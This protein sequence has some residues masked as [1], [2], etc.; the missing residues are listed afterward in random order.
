MNI[1]F[2]YLYRDGSNNKNCGYL[3]FANPDNFTPAYI[4]QRLEAALD[5]EMYFIASQVDIPEVFLWDEEADYDPEDE[6]TFPA[7]LGAGTYVV[8]EDD[9]GWHEFLEVQ[10]TT[11][12]ATDP[13][14]TAAF[15]TEMDNAKLQGWKEFTPTAKQNAR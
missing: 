7:D 11:E 5:N 13:R 2:T 12:A 9:H 3:I 10:E 1:D 15:L 6:S 14:T 8:N 4:H